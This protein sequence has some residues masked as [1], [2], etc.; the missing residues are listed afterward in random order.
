MGLRRVYCFR[1]VISL[2]SGRHGGMDLMT[3]VLQLKDADSSGRTGMGKE[4]EV[5][6]ST[7]RT[8]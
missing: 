6:P 4:D 5:S 7:S 3:G 8:A 2:G 1:A